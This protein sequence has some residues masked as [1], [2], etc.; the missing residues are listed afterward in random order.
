MI[1]II[2]GVVGGTIVLV[3]AGLYSYGFKRRQQKANNNSRRGSRP[4]PSSLEC[5]PFPP[6][7]AAAARIGAS[8]AQTTPV[9]DYDDLVR[10][11]RSQS[12][13]ET[14][15]A[16][17]TCGLRRIVEHAYT[18]R[19]DGDLTV[20]EGEEV[21]EVAVED[22]GWTVVRNAQGETGHIP[23]NYLHPST[24]HAPSAPDALALL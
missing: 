12:T 18:A 5:T 23:S 21:E 1:A 20:L 19:D 2:A 14:R 9:A 13:A 4:P 10:A 7:A 8:A 11:M 16:Q 24:N 6:A 3:A 17:L 15:P 22:G